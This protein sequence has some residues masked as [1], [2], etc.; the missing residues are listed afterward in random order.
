MTRNKKYKSFLLDEIIAI[1]ILIIFSLF[2]IAEYIV[3]GR[4]CNGVTI[5]EQF[6][7]VSYVKWIVPTICVC[8]ALHMFRQESNSGIC[9]LLLYTISGGFTAAM[10]LFMIYLF[11]TNYFP[12]NYEYYNVYN[13]CIEGMASK[14]NILYVIGIVYLQFL[15][16]CMCSS[17][18]LLF[19]KISGKFNAAV[20]LPALIIRLFNVM[21]GLTILPNVFNLGMLSDGGL[22]T[23]TRS[24][25]VGTAVLGGLTLANFFILNILIQKKI[26]VF[27]HSKQGISSMSCVVFVIIFIALFMCDIFRA[28]ILN[29]D[30][31]S[32]FNVL[33][34][35]I[36]VLNDPR[37]TLIFGLCSLYLVS[38][39]LCSTNVRMCS[40]LIKSAL[41][42]VG[43]LL[44]ILLMTFVLFRNYGMIRWTWTEEFINSTIALPM[45]RINIDYSRHT[46]AEVFVL[47]FG[48]KIGALYFVTV[49]YF[50]FY[51]EWFKHIHIALIFSMMTLDITIANCLN[52]K[53]YI[54]SIMSWSR[55]QV[56]AETNGLMPA[57]VIMLVIMLAGGVLMSFR[58]VSRRDVSIQNAVNH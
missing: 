6:R 23:Y 48:L 42:I 20:L 57:P 22:Y 1:V 53:F 30:P 52:N 7:S 44:T 45:Q 11:T 12:C 39:D 14:N 18:A 32:S 55:Y 47:S 3:D 16:G 26:D 21:V 5:F 25:T 24:I 51:K 15:L 41:K 33:E 38:E 35:Y 4:E 54:I 34:M 17:C 10:S 29:Y 8:P 36:A 37:C 2:S 40:L 58:L 56:V 9:K 19:S 49:I 43:M 46:I 28:V 50:Y 31:T 13:Y 27:P